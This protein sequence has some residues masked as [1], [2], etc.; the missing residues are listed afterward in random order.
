[1]GDRGR[2][3][4]LRRKGRSFFRKTPH[5]GTLLP[6]PERSYVPILN[7]SFGQHGEEGIVLDVHGEPHQLPA[8]R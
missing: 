3:S 8:T 6:V 4:P 5:C 1:M 7:N 2:Y